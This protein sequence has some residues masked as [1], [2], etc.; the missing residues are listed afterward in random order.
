MRPVNVSKDCR[1]LSKGLV[2]N[3]VKLFNFC[4][5]GCYKNKFLTYKFCFKKTCFHIRVVK[6]KCCLSIEF[7]LKIS[8]EHYEVY[9]F[10]N[11]DLVIT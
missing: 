8:Y 3:V 2:V 11:D 4:I 7:Q 9:Q 5:Y 6:C 10:Y 1:S